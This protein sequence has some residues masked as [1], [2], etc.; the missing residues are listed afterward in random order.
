MYDG[1]GMGER[2]IYVDFGMTERVKRNTL[3]R[4]EKAAKMG[5]ESS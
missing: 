2:A 3:K 1:C 4:L 5:I